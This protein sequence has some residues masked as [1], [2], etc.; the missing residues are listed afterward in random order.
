MVRKRVGG[1]KMTTEVG[2]KI[3]YDKVTGNVLIDTGE[4]SG[5]VRETTREEDFITY[6]ALADRVPETVDMIQLEFGK[7]RGDFAECN[8]YR[9]NP[10]TLELEF[11][12]PDPGDSEPQEPVYRK[13]LSVEVDELKYSDIENRQ[14]IAELTMMIAAP[15]IEGEGE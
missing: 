7:Y 10:I 1:I 2:K 5:Y 8:G 13:P 15:M 4:L 11:S 12:Y 14:A 6:K 3:Y 9:V